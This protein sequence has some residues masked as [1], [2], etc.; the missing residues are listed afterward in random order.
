MGLL[1]IKRSMCMKLKVLK[2][3]MEL[4]WLSKKKKKDQD[5]IPKADHPDEL[6]KKVGQPALLKKIDKDIPKMHSYIILLQ[7]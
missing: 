4:Q 1:L 7:V 5:A 2:L 3:F 6:Q